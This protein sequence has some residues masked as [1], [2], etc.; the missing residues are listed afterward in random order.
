MLGT[1][2]LL[3]YSL[4]AYFYLQKLLT[5]HSAFNIQIYLLSL[6][7]VLILTSVASPPPK[8]SALP[9]LPNLDRLQLR[10]FSIIAFNIV[11]RSRREVI[12]TEGVL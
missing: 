5:Q 12:A 7:S 6:M 1:I 2:D 10:S 9:G 8:S 11:V 4:H 3:F